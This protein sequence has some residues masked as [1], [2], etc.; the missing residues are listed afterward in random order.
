MDNC[1]ID[2][3]KKLELINGARCS[4]INGVRVKRRAKSKIRNVTWVVIRI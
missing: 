1:E 4:L 3:K 2:A